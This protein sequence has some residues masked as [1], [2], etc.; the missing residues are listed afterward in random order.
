[1]NKEAI[2]DEM[3]KLREGMSNEEVLE[4]SR[5]MCERFAETDLYKR[6]ARIA[7]YMPIKNEADLSILTKRALADGKCVLVP[8]TD[9]LKNSI[10]FAKITEAS[11]FSEG[12]FGIKEPMQKSRIAPEYLD[13]ILTPGLAFDFSGGRLGWGKGY[14]DRAL[15]KTKAKLVGAGYEFQLT[16]AVPM[17]VHD[18]RMDYILTESELVVCG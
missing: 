9:T 3:R 8:V 1:M 18:R 17:E 14:Y 2:R 6:A 13:L 12:A 16:G 4:K 10:S 7:V 11:M 15:E 5:I